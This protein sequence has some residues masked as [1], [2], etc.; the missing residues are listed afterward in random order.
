MLGSISKVHY[1]LLFVFSGKVWKS[2]LNLNHNIAILSLGWE[3]QA[4]SAPRR[5]TE[6][7]SKHFC[8]CGDYLHLTKTSG[9]PGL[10]QPEPKDVRPARYQ[11]PSWG[12]R[13]G[14]QGWEAMTNWRTGVGHRDAS[15]SNTRGKVRI[16]KWLGTRMQSVLKQKDKNKSQ[17][18]WSQITNG[19][20]EI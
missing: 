17:V 16:K 5:A 14:G 6:N 4:N 19:Q 10:A 18:Q 15:T 13:Q 3:L 9:N 7:S 8:K 12:Q 1:E 2:R 20:G 11:R